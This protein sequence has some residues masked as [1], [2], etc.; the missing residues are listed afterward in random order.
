MPVVRIMA[1]DK[2]PYSLNIVGMPDVIADAQRQGTASWLDD[3]DFRQVEWMD[4][5]MDVKMRAAFQVAGNPWHVG[6]FHAS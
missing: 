4:A 6:D 1:F 3:V 5:S 2:P